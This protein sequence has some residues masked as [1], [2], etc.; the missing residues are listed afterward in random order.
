MT[1][2]V[3]VMNDG[4]CCASWCSD[5]VFVNVKSS[6]FCF[7][8]SVASFPIVFSLD[9]TRRCFVLDPLRGVV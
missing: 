2:M 5:G 8:A 1:G 7:R 3:G 6:F 9:W 4:F